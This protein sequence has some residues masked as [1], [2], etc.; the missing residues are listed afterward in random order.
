MLQ[1]SEARKFPVECIHRTVSNVSI[2][3]FNVRSAVSVAAAQTRCY[4]ASPCGLL[5][6]CSFF[7]I[8]SRN[9]YISFLRYLVEREDF[10][11]LLLLHPLW[12]RFVFLVYTYI[13]PLFLYV[14]SSGSVR[15]GVWT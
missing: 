6:S 10:L 2:P 12:V 3:A 8:G 11:L 15:G 4:C 1:T 13:S 9:I 14:L 5:D 7:L